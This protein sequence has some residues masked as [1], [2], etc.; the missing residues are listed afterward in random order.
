MIERCWSQKSSDRPTF[1][2]LLNELRTNH[3][4][5]LETVDKNEYFNYIKYIDEY[6]TSFDS[7]SVIIPPTNLKKYQLSLSVNYFQIRNENSSIPIIERFQSTAKH[8]PYRYL[9]QLGHESKLLVNKAALGQTESQFKVGQYLIEGRNDFP[10]DTK[11]GIDYLKES[12]NN[13]NTDSLIYYIDMLIK[14]KMIPSNHLKERKLLETRLKS[15]DEGAYYLMYGKL[16]K[17]EK[18]YSLSKEYFERSMKTGNI[19]SHYEYGELIR[20]GYIESIIQGEIDKCYMKAINEGSLKAMFKYGLYL[21]SN[22]NEIKGSQWIKLSADKGYSKALYYMGTLME[23][24][25]SNEDNVVFHD[26]ESIQ[27]FKRAAYEGHTESMNKYG[28]KLLKLLQRSPN[29]ENK[30]EV[31]RFLK[32]A[33]DKGCLESMNEYGKLITEENSGAHYNPKEGARFVKIAAENGYANAMASYA[34][35]LKYGKGVAVNIN[36]AVRYYKMGIENGS[37]QAMNDYGYML[38]HGQGVGVNYE[39]AIKYYKMAIDNGY[40]VA[41]NNYARML[42]NGD[43]IKVDYQEAIKFYKMA[44]DKGNPTA[45]NNYA[46]MLKSG[47]GVEINYQ[48]AIKYFKM[49]IDVGNPIAMNN[50]AHMLQKGIGV[51]A[52]YH[53]AIKYYKMAIEKGFSTAM[54]NYAKM[55]KNG[56]GVEIDYQESIKYFKMAINKGNPSAMNNYA[57]M[58]KNGIGVDIDLKEACKYYKM[59]TDKGFAPAMKNYARMLLEGEGVSINKEEAENYFEKVFAEKK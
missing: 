18:N 40:S 19:E 35:L 17:N 13:G 44:I 15:K 41:M 24:D 51:E 52:N 57:D 12:M 7:C 28:C 34:R 59:A 54:N 8:F 26:D 27:Y 1:D 22:S 6:K 21:K 31:I 5:I 4:Y 14:G 39:E 50:Y 23:I 32:K 30:D 33:C 46:H 49:A 47:Q 20:K 10:N 48:E 3:E 42:Q 38:K 37:V 56:D 11:K 2:Q 43:G 29:V 9:C 53:E 25:K 58:L 55:L 16:F 36:E 45:M